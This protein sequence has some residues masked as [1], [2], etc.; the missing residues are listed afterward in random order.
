MPGIAGVISRRPRD[1]N[2]EDLEVMLASMRHEPWYTTRRYTNDTLGFYAGLLSHPGALSAS[3]PVTNA[4][5]DVIILFVGEHFSDD[6]LDDT[7]RATHLVS[8]Y[9]NE[10]DAF[11]ACLNGWF[12]GA[13][14][15]LRN[16]RV[17]LFNDRYG[18]E[19][20]YYHD[21]A[22]P[23]LFASEAKA[24]LRVRP[25]LRRIE[26]RSL[27]ELVA[28]ECVLENRSLF[29]N[30][31][32]LPRGSAWAWSPGKDWTRRSYFSPK[33]WQDQ[34]L[35]ETRVFYDRL[36][37]TFAAILPRYF[38]EREPIGMSLTAGLDSRL[39]MACLAPAPGT[40]PCYS[41]CGQ[42]RDTLDVT[43]GRKVA[44]HCRQPYRVIRLDDSFFAAFPV[45]AE[46]AV[47]IADG[48]LDICSVHD[49]Y[50]SR[51]ARDIAPIRM[52]GLFGSEILRN[53]SMFKPS[54]RHHQFFD[55]EFLTHLHQALDAFEHQENRSALS[56]ALFT[57]VPSHAFGKCALER[58]QLT[59]RTPYMDND[60]A[61]LLYSMPSGGRASNEIQL[62]LM[63]DFD[64]ALARLRTNRGSRYGDSVL[65]SKGLGLLYLFTIKADYTYFSALPHWLVRLDRR[66]ASLHLDRSLFGSQKFEGYRLWFRDQLADYVQAILLDQRAVQRPCFDPK[67][68][69]YMV[70]AHVR[71]T[72]N[73]VQEINK[74]LTVE[75]VHRQLVEA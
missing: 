52:T 40:L 12:S 21:G 67:R 37:E 2:Q 47:F 6:G 39:I 63:N 7:Q 71:G 11:L 50:F 32:M 10:G 42:H 26:P 20:I 56:F 19:R 29:S 51:R 3:M 57:E 70:A 75:L 22:D 34:P 66:L 4:R 23:F 54:L 38:R 44:E 62:R 59:V 5:G 14:V 8:L 49:L 28:L 64:Q 16:E 46:K 25:A 74:A 15:D 1:E 41:F 35:L 72:G 43:I 33:T 58:S 27:A 48:H 45:L 17:L 36:R 30:V 53:R 73:Y 65:L 60:L 69:K 9:E 31:F 18:M 55:R 68:L 24:L 13:L 61:R